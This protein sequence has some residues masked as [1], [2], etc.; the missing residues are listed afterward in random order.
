MNIFRFIARLPQPLKSLYV[1]FIVVFIVGIIPVLLRVPEASRWMSGG[2]GFAGVLL[3][4]CLLTNLNN[5]IDGLAR[6]IKSEEH[7]GAGNA[8]SFLSTPAFARL[9]GGTAVVVGTLF[10]I[11]FF[12][13]AMKLLKKAAYEN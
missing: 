4:I 5:S 6:A 9:F 11:S 10:L 8:E 2:V 13:G 7:W 1:L 12:T 3:G